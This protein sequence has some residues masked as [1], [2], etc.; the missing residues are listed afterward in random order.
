MIE[1]RRSDEIFEWRKVGKFGGKDV[2]GE[3]EVDFV[4][5]G[6]ERANGRTSTE[7]R[8]RGRHA[9]SKAM[10]RGQHGNVDSLFVT[11][12]VLGWNQSR[13]S[14]A[15]TTR[16]VSQLRSA[17]S[18]HSINERLNTSKLARAEASTP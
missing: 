18:A 2:V 7:S 5:D 1:K 6:N 17:R 16:N 13:D 12:V 15:R 4:I 10:H 8:T 14:N 11:F 3:Q 9:L